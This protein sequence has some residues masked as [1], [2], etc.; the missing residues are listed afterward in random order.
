VRRFWIRR[1]LPLIF[2]LLP[3]PPALVVAVAL[4][5]E[6]R[7]FYLERV[8]HSTIDWVILGLGVALFLLQLRLSWRAMQ[9]KETGFDERAETQL[10]HLAQAAEW[11]PL[12]G[13]LGTVAGILQTFHAIRP[14]ITQQ[15]VIN[16]YAPAITATASGLLM[17]LLN[18]LPIWFVQYGQDKIRELG[19][20]PAKGKLLP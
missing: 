19:V 16:Q 18:I 15:E 14:D 13:L 6:A 20:L 10:S 12:L 8:R 9:W 1:V 2:C 4:P 3:L 7:N 11:F 17:A 5:T